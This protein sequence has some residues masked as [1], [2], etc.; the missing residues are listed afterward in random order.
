MI[1]TRLCV[2]L[3]APSIVYGGTMIIGFDQKVYE[4]VFFGTEEATK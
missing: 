1:L 4:S 2:D 3:R